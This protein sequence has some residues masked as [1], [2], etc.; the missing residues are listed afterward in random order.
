MFKIVIVP[1]W[2][3]PFTSDT[4]GIVYVAVFS[5]FNELTFVSTE[6]NVGAVF[7]MLTVKLLLLVLFNV[8]L[9]VANKV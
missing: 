3:L 5:W 7:K 9:T 8:S 6:V 2:Q 4:E 1:L